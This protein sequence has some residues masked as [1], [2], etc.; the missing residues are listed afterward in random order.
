M[1]KRTKVAW[2]NHILEFTVV[3]IGIL[4]AFQLNRCSEIRKNEDLVSE[5]LEYIIE[6]TRFN[7]NMLANTISE[8][9][10][11]QQQLDT[12]VKLVKEEENTAKMNILSLQVMNLNN[13]YIKKVA[14]QTFVQSGDIR[15]VTNF[16]EKND[17]IGLYE[18]Y[19]YAEGMNEMTRST[20][21]QFFYPYMVKNMDLLEAGV[22]EKSFYTNKEFRNILSVYQYTLAA[23][24]RVHKQ[25]LGRIEEFLEKYQI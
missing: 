12:L 17:V 3:L 24:I 21:I 7:R 10:A 19:K 25:T 11:L 16:D 4:I 20:Y 13:S 23:R 14:Y 22:Q 1:G 9:E 5:H 15:F 8:S 6:E 18:Y 2:L